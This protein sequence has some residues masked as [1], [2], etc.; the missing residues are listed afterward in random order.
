MTD[1]TRLQRPMNGREWL[2]LL[3]LAAIWGGSFF[4]IAIA[5]SAF[6]PL[7]AV[8]FRCAIGAVGIIAFLMVTRQRIPTHRE[9]LIAFAGMAILNNVI[10]QSLIVWAQQSL[11]SGY[12]SILNATTPF[13]TV[14]LMHAFTTNERATPAKFLGVAIGLGG[15]ATMIGLD[16]I[17]RSSNQILPQVAILAA[18][19]SYGLSSLWGRRMLALG[20]APYVAATGQLIA[21]SIITLPLA[22]IFEA[23]LSGPSATPGQWLAI[24]ALGLICTAL[25][26]MI[27]FRI[28][29]TAGGTNLSL[30]TFLIPVSAI[31]LGIVFLGEQLHLRHI[32]GFALIGVGL[33]C[34]DG[35]LLIKAGL[36]KPAQ[37]PARG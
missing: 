2:L 13:F 20:I 4:F 17:A 23:P 26:Y 3:T 15:V 22:L 33:A 1:H 16:I 27:F 32:I 28:L 14:L 18:A 6:K 25:A 29:S 12:A 21:S 8:F 37:D 35:R 30:V 31:L 24:I 19:F 7:T 34:I 10:P 11:P 5:I 36:M 9:A